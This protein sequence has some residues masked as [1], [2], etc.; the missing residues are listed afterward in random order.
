[1]KRGLSLVLGIGLLLFGW[2]SFRFVQASGDH[3]GLLEYRVKVVGR[4]GEG[5]PFVALDDLGE[6]PFINPTTDETVVPLRSLTTILSSA[7]DVGWN[8]ATRTAQFRNGDHLLSVQVGTAGEIRSQLDGNPYPMRAFVCD[9]RLHAPLR[10]VTDAFG[11]EVRWY[12]SERTA[13]ID[14]VWTTG[15][16]APVSQPTTAQRPSA[17]SDESPLGWSDL[18]AH[19]MDAWSRTVRRT[20]CS[21]V[22]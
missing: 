17:C 22:L 15:V 2:S 11:L 1:M 13:V 9:G 18:F 3:C 8:E 10:K 19:P 14:P 16:H 4:S 12:H 7:T 6:V 21:L 20:A 5:R